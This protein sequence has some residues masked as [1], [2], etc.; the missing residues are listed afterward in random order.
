MSIKLYLK[1][2]ESPLY[3]NKLQPMCNNTSL[4]E[5]LKKEK[6]IPNSFN[7]IIK[8]PNKNYIVKN[9]ELL[10]E[11][12]Y[13]KVFSIDNNKVFRISN[14]LNYHNKAKYDIELKGLFIQSYLSKPLN[15]GGLECPN[16][17]KVYEF[18]Y[19]LS[20]ILPNTSIFNYI[21]PNISTNRKIIGTYAILEYVPFLL[22]DHYNNISLNCKNIYNGIA[23]ALNCM[24]SNNIV[25]L[26]LKFDNVGLTNDF[27]PKIYDFTGALF[28]NNKKKNL[29]CIQSPKEIVITDLY[30]D[31]SFKDILCINFDI[32]SLGIMIGMTYFKYIIYE[33][34]VKLFLDIPSEIIKQLSSIEYNNLRNLLPHLLQ[35]YPSSRYVS[36]QVISHPF[37]NNELSTPSSILILKNSNINNSAKNLLKTPKNHINLLS[38]TIN[39]LKKKII[40]IN[41]N[42]NKFLK[43][44]QKKLKLLRTN[45]EISILNRL[46]N[47]NIN[48]IKNKINIIK[49]QI[50]SYNKNEKLRMKQKALESLEN[51]LEQWKIKESENRVNNFLSTGKFERIHK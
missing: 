3:N 38:K 27:Q 1:N 15:E 36:S 14:K 34:K 20:G 4:I 37:F 41:I 24:H 28:L 50:S 30:A 12:T 48:L 43:N 16:I 7:S 17:C 31:P 40:D 21:L 46:N 9:S 51:K 19:I 47:E 5:N 35:Y 39:I 11:G 42:K 29:D 32:Y 45:L 26:D 18:G 8:C 6:K 22:L 25:H 33:N 49:K 23:N 2:S 10:G 13:N 44:K